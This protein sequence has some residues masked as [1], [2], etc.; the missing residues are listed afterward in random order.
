MSFL[1]I[2][3]VAFVCDSSKLETKHSKLKTQNSKLR[4]G[5]W[6]TIGVK[7]GAHFKIA[8]GFGVGPQLFIP[9]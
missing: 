5:Q 7:I 3:A 2:T 4:K 8:A 1:S 9:G 6:H